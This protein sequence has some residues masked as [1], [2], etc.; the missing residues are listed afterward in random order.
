MMMMKRP[1]IHTLLSE[2]V[3]ATLAH[4]PRKKQH[5]IA[6]PRLALT[7]ISSTVSLGQSHLV[8]TILGVAVFRLTP[9]KENVSQ[10]PFLRDLICNSSCGVV[11]PT[12]RIGACAS[13]HLRVC[14]QRLPRADGGVSVLHQWHLSRNRCP[15]RP[16]RVLPLCLILSAPPRL[17]PV[18]SSTWSH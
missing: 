1:M 12:A 11:R 17:I 15:C 4:T 7:H 2:V 3:K 10:H 8:M 13:V 16:L 18:A 6:P 14:L 5:A 9:L